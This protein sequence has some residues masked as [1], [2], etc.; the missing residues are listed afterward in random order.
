MSNMRNGAYNRLKKKIAEKI[1]SE[2]GIPTNWLAGRRGDNNT[3]A[4]TTPR[5]DDEG[6]N[7]SIQ[8][9]GQRDMGDR[10]DEPDDTLARDARIKKAVFEKLKQ[11]SGLP[12]YYKSRHN[13]VSDTHTILGTTPRDDDDGTN[14]TIK[15]S[16]QDDVGRDHDT[17]L[18]DEDLSE[19]MTLFLKDMDDII[20][21]DEFRNKALKTDILN[22]LNGI[23]KKYGIH[24][25][26]R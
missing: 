18:E 16:G 17:D 15:N 11:E 22:A 25:S 12:A 13:P 19:G 2:G 26:I 1:R 6:T 20:T 3:F 8:H 23:Y 4:A 21:S 7:F 24:R 9:S 10:Q 14:F 5:D